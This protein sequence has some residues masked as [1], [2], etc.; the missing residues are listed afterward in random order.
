[1]NLRPRFL[2][3]AVAILCALLPRSVSADV[4]IYC[5]GLPGCHTGPV[6][7]FVANVLTLLN[8]VLPPLVYLCG[9]L[10]IIIGG[11]YIVLSAGNSERVTKGKNTIIWSAIGIFAMEV[12][13]AFNPITYFVLPE[14]KPLTSMASVD[15]IPGAISIA[16]TTAQDLLYVALLGVAIFSGARMVLSGGKEDQYNKGK[17]G[18]FWAAVG[19][20]IVNV[21]A[22]LADAFQNI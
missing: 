10:F 14:V 4:L 5:G 15:L 19:A 7:P 8:S 2:P 11:M 13:V 9:G 3:S 17:E 16:I 18:L 6:Q 12:I 22:S 21:F 20:I 1:M